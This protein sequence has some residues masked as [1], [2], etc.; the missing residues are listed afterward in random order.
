M[1]TSTEAMI[2][3]ALLD[4]LKLLTFSPALD[5]AEPGIQFPAA[6]EDKPDNYLAV[7]FLPN[8]TRQVT[9][10]D[11]PQQKR[12]MLQISVFWKIGQGVIKPLDIAGQIINHYRNQTLW[13]G[14]TRVTIYNEPWAASPI[15]DDRVQIPVTISWHAFEKET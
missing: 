5:V 14:T 8:Q 4:H 6:G 7:T 13:A 11:D 1:A 2:L 15:Q 9:L 12:G 10:G 3:A